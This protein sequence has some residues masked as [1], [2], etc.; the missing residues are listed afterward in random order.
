MSED[1]DEAVDNKETETD[2]VPEGSFGH[3]YCNKNPVNRH[4]T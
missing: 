2:E 4:L 3:I 1:D